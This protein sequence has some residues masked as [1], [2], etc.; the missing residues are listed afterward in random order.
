MSRSDPMASEV[1][2]FAFADSIAF[3]N[4]S[5]WDLVSAR[6]GLF[7]SRR[8]LGLLEQNRPENLTMHYTL[9]YAKGRPVVAIVAQSLD[10]RVAD[11]SSSRAKEK[12]QGLWR[13]LEKATVRSIT[14]G[15]KRYLL[16]EALLPWARLDG[17]VQE[18]DEP[19]LWP[20]VASSLGRRWHG[21]LTAA[22]HAAELPV[23]WVH[24]RMLVCGNLLS[25]GPHG[26]AFAEGE[27][28]ARLWPVVEEALYRIRRSIKLFG[29]SDLVMIKDLTDDQKS[30]A[31]A[32]RR[33]HFR[34]FETEPNMILPFEPGW[35]NFDDYLR[36]MRSEYR[37]RIRRTIRSLETAGV[38]LERIGT[39]QVKAQATE[40]YDLYLQVHEHQKLR[41]TTIRPQWI[42]ALAGSFGDDFR[43]VIARPKEGGKLLGFANVIRDGNSAHGLYIGFDRAAAA[44]EIPLYLG[45]VYAAVGQGIEMGAE[46]MSL[47][48]TALAPKAQIG[49][50]AQPMRGYLRHRNPALNL[51]VPSILALLPTPAEPPE[52][53]PFKSAA[54]RHN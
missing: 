50:K 37:I 10:I 38:V 19:G 30:A 53:H 33:F 16:F 28:P 36:D 45:L 27:D 35:R 21:L 43:T 48:R 54:S 32:L 31:A 9:A 7:L 29:D 44:K 47:G 6:S 26:V 46:Q 15:R 41:L 14:R 18:A 17:A 42:P 49:A 20:D 12:G 22:E 25:T 8:F 4:A 23:A 5:D 40:I 34:R 39:E 51:A 3:L 1:I 52:R 11:L 2:G 24:Q 13:S